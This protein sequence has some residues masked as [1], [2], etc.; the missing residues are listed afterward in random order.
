MTGYLTAS[1]RLLL[2]AMMLSLPGWWIAGR[3]VFR[4]PADC[5]AWA[6]WAVAPIESEAQ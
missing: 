6:Q 5:M 1:L 4:T 3:R 2:I